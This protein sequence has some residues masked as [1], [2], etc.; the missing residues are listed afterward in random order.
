MNGY[1]AAIAQSRRY[2]PLPEASRRLF[3]TAKSCCMGCQQ[4]Y[5]YVAPTFEGSKYG[6]NPDIIYASVFCKHNKVCE[7]FR[8]CPTRMVLT[9]SPDEEEPE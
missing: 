6:E 3:L 9:E 8:N 7:Q 4:A 5:W 1:G 2:E